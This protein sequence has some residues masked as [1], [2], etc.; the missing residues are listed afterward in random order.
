MQIII[1]ILAFNKYEISRMQAMMS[2]MIN[3]ILALLDRDSNMRI[4]K[5]LNHS[6]AVAASIISQ[7]TKKG[8]ETEKNGRLRKETNT[9]Y[10][11]DNATK[12]WNEE[13]NNEA[14]LS[15][16]QSEAVFKQ[17]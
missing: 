5:I 14:S 12:K 8:K 13:K 3:S 17:I 16:L 2:S 15:T 11:I 10:E 6:V 1:Y 9:V 4:Y 7:Y